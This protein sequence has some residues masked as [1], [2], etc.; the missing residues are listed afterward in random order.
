MTGSAGKRYV[1]GERAANRT[2]S[3]TWLQAS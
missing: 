2:E 3:P 1:A